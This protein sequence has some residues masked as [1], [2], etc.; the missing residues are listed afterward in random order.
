MLHQFGTQMPLSTAISKLQVIQN[1]AIRI[2]TG[3][4][5]MSPINHLHR[6]GALLPVADSLTLLCK[7]HL[8][9]VLT[10]DHPSFEVVTAGSGP[11]SIRATLQSRFLPSIQQHLVDGSIPPDARKPTIKILHT[12]AVASS[13][14]AAGHNRVINSIPPPINPE[15][16]LLPRPYRS[17]L[18]QLRSGYCS[19]LND[20]KFRV[21][22]SPSPF[23][24]ECSAEEHSVSHLFSCPAYPTQLTPLDL[25]FDAWR[26]S[27]FLS[28]LPYFSYLPPL[29]RLFKLLKLF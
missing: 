17:C 15:E 1:S 19:A 16:F 9:S 27:S 12:E 5:R 4:H 11:R 29:E 23:C 8:A 2:A 28:S 24:T 22:R 3:C 18:P 10:A 6:E 13:I 21:G 26:V 20:Y 14:A 25:W 7:Q